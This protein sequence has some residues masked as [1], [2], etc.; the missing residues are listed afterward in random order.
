MKT[1]PC[2]SR[3]EVRN[4][5]DVALA[6]YT[7][8]RLQK[9]YRAAPREIDDVVALYDAYDSTSGAP[10]AILEG[11][12]LDQALRLTIQASYAAVQ[13]GRKLAHIREA[14]MLGIALCPICGISPPGHLDHHLPIATYHPLAIYVRN[15]VP[16]CSDCNHLK[17]ATIGTVATQRFV[18]P[19][20]EKLPDVSFLRAYVSIANGGIVTEFGIDPEVEMPAQMR[21]R[22]LFQIERLRLNQR[23][24]REI[25]TY[26]TSHVTALCFAFDA[27]H[28]PAIRSFLEAQRQVE[29]GAF[30]LNHWR[31]AL[32][33]A[34][35]EHGE[36]CAGAF[37]DVL[38]VARGSRLAMDLEATR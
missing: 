21:Q 12:N 1:L 37:M 14:L 2:P 31:P 10:S 22:L 20:F 27:G 29:L 32:L 34:L 8:M 16:L 13:Q 30:H 19:Y 17:G 26:L 35:S 15:L 24:G 25:N 4:H 3:D 28:G 38:P 6:P 33:R 36:F 18:H 5:L 23:Y 7:W 9:G 11:T